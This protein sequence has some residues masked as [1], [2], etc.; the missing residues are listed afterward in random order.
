MKN[1]GRRFKWFTVFR[2]LG[3]L[4]F[5]I[6]IART[7][8]HELLNWL[9]NVDLWFLLGAL[10]LQVML[11]LVKSVRWLLL[12]EKKPDITKMFQRFGE[13]QEAYALGTVTPGRMGELM[14][15]G[16]AQGRSGVVTSGLLVIAERGFD[17]SVFFLVAGITLSLD[18]FSVLGPAVGYLLILVALTGMTIAVSILVFPVVVRWVDW[19]MKRIRILPPDKSLAFEKRSSGRILMFLLLSLVSNLIA[20]LSFYFTALAANVDLGFMIVSGSVALAG[21]MNTIPVTIMGIGT[22]D[23]TL[24]YVLNEVPR[25]QVIAFSSLILMVFQIFGGVLALIGGQL[26]LRLATKRRPV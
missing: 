25:A 4:V 24:I 26:F 19:I 11:L 12:N 17:L 2:Y 8:L 23:I 6:V 5:I 1:G 18:F 20:F 15:A 14:K 9:K 13:F 22:R 3:V 10:L 16:H 21:V 7:D